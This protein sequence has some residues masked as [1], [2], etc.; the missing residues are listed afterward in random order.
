MIIIIYH[1][2]ANAPILSVALAD[3]LYPQKHPKSKPPYPSKTLTTPSAVHSNQN[4]YRISPPG[5]SA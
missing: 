1:P 2:I 4:N 5:L 3:L